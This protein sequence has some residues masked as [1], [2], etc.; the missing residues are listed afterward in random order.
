MIPLQTAQ[1]MQSSTHF[2]ASHTWPSVQGG[3]QVTGQVSVHDSSRSPTQ[4]F[5]FQVGVLC[6][7]V[8]V[9]W[10]CLVGSLLS[11]GHVTWHSFP[12]TTS[13]GCHSQSMHLGQLEQSLD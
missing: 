5:A 7:R 1:H 13:Q 6:F 4:S 9:P 3:S 12:P 10:N 2:P 8:L 11:A